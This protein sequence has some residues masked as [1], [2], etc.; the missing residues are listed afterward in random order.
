MSDS[1]QNTPAP[2]S[3]ERVP[4]HKPEVRRLAISSD[5][6]SD[7]QQSKSETDFAED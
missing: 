3:E 5:T 2:S 1:L 4:W 6:Q 7:P